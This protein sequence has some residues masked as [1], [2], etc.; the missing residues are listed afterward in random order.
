MYK[1]RKFNG[2]GRLLA[3]LECEVLAMC[4]LYA[5]QNTTGKGKCDIVDM[6]TGEILFVTEGQ[7]QNVFPKVTYE[8][9]EVKSC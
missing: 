7:G 9:K 4:K 6:T 3:E 1:I 2:K 5:L 8:V